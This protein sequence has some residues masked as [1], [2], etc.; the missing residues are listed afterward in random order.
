MLIGSPS[1]LAK[2]SLNLSPS[3][4]VGDFCRFLDADEDDPTSDDTGAQQQHVA[5]CQNDADS[6]CLGDE[7]RELTES[8]AVPCGNIFPIVCRRMVNIRA[9]EAALAAAI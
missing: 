2:E 9:N 1:I 4:R 6:D 7:P 8:G 3:L 5:A